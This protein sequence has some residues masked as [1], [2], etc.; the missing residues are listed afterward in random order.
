[1]ATKIT[2]RDALELLAGTAGLAL[3]PVGLSAQTAALA[4]ERG[5]VIRT[6]LRDVAPDTIAGPT[7][8]HE[9]L[10]IRYP[11]TRAMA[12]ALLGAFWG[13]IYLRRR[14]CV[15][16]MVSHSG[17]DLVQIAQFLAVGR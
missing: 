5:A 2:R 10:S 3:G 16:P 8:F 13:V 17:F 9:H 12:T 6:L 4:F 15:A 1:M 14:C 7:L 11:L